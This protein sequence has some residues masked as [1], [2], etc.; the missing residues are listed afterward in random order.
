MKR[1]KLKKVKRVAKII[2]IVFGIALILIF[3]AIGTIRFINAKK[4]HISQPNGIQENINV[5]IVPVKDVSVLNDITKKMAELD[6]KQ[7]YRI[8]DFDDE[9][10]LLD[11]EYNCA[12]HALDD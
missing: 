1:A 5:E 3:I 11:E 8:S 12:E 6:F 4:N 7:K 10:G 2:F 9:I